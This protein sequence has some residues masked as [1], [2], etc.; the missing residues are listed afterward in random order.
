MRSLYA[1][2]HTRFGERISGRERGRRVQNKI[3]GLQ[4]H[5]AERY[6]P[7]LARVALGTAKRPR[8]A[9]VG[10]GFAG[11]MA[12]YALRKVC[13]VT[14][15][16]ARDRVGGRVWSQ[17]KSSG[18]IETGGELIGYAHPQWL[19]LARKFGLGLS[20]LSTDANFEGLS[21]EM[22][23]YLDGKKLDE[24]EAGSIYKDMTP[25]VNALCEHAKVIEDPYH[26]W[27]A[28]GAEELDDK[29]MS[30]WIAGLDCE[31]L[32]R[33]A[34]EQEFSNDGG[35]PTKNQ[36]YLGNLAVIAGAA[37][38]GGD[39]DFFT[40]TENL[41]CSEGNQALATRLAGAIMDGG[42]KI[43]LSAPASKIRIGRRNVTVELQKS[44]VTADYAILAI[45][46]NLYP[47]RAT[48]TIEIEPALPAGYHIS[49]G[50]AVK[51]LSSLKRR[52]WIGKGLSPV[53]TSDQFGV[54]WEGT[55]NQI[56]DSGREVELNLFAGSAVAQEALDAY[57]SGGLGAVQKFYEARIGA[58]YKNYAAN[59]TQPPTF[60]AWPLEP[61]TGG[62]YSSPAPGE[63]CT[64]GKRLS[65]PFHD[66]LFF[67]G[68][69][70]CPAYYG[71]M[72][73]ALQSG[74]TAAARILERVR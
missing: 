69:H 73:G 67:A 1:Q 24:D 2:L 58:V 9:I 39:D 30:K 33:K 19:T 52:F 38:H 28:E 42:G 5:F 11:L 61:W 74:K 49:M 25:A 64:A 35:T 17:K 15:F 40:Q 41:R 36:S 57:K 51:Y 4:A 47:P 62:G 68:E 20:V 56:A 55:D 12:A 14:V 63:V 54:T 72:E 27:L 45:P 18:I 22:P 44:R 32:T 34:I 13:D 43:Y 59:C 26:P 31:P 48:A 66:R 50:T 29:P 71:Y 60:M 7:H 16:E 3:S 53:A 23:L 6:E 46:S 10:A 70:T 21:L 65:E 37:R 8:V